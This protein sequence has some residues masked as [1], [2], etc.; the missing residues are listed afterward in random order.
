MQLVERAQ[1]DVSLPLDTYCT[2]HGLRRVYVL[3]AEDLKA[4]LVILE[5]PDCT[6]PIDA[7][8]KILMD[9]LGALDANVLHAKTLLKDHGESSAYE[10]D[11]LLDVAEQ[12]HEEIKNATAALEKMGLTDS[13]PAR[14]SSASRR[15]PRPPGKR[16]RR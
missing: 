4:R 16:G 2:E 1:D 13:I 12:L 15:G 8:K 5:N 3:H 6:L 11:S 9:V 14:A 7:K 10:G